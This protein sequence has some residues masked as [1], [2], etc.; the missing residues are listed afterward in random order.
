MISFCVFLMVVPSWTSNI[1][2]K[3]LICLM[4]PNATVGDYCNDHML[5]T[6]K[7][8]HETYASLN[9]INKIEN[10]V[11]TKTF[12]INPTGNCSMLH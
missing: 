8:R 11:T 12:S 7:F 6:D 9:I 10:G 4:Q 5:C 2:K 3:N 1:S